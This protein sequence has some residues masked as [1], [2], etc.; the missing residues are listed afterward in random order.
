MKLDFLSPASSISSSVVHL[1]ALR[2]D[3]YRCDSSDGTATKALPLGIERR[4]DAA[5]F[6]IGKRRDES[7]RLSET[8][9]NNPEGS[10]PSHRR[11][12]FQVSSVIKR[13]EASSVVLLRL[14]SAFPRHSRCAFSSFPPVPFQLYGCFPRNEA[15][16]FRLKNMPASLRT[17]DILY[18]RRTLRNCSETEKCTPYIS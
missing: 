8:T 4:F 14:S 9:L 18:W 6:E 16:S 15:N 11:R 5:W 17:L 13:L 3:S 10:T 2:R 1:L 12:V 7:I